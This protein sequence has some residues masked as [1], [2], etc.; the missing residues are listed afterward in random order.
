MHG[1]VRSRH[2]RTSTSNPIIW[3]A[4]VQLSVRVLEL[5]GFLATEDLAQIGSTMLQAG[6]IYSPSSICSRVQK[7]GE[8]NTQAELLGGQRINA[9]NQVHTPEC[10]KRAGENSAHECGACQAW[11]SGTARQR[12]KRRS[13]ASDNSISH[14]GCNT[15]QLRGTMYPETFATLHMS[16]GTGCSRRHGQCRLHVTP[17]TETGKFERAAAKQDSSGVRFDRARRAAVSRCWSLLR[18]LQCDEQV[19]I[20]TDFEQPHLQV[21]AVHR[22]MYPSPL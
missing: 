15:Q 4:N 19:S 2:E 16:V 7:R 18:S 22:L 8:N 20:P 17:H 10:R 21:R 6:T 13:Q 1:S 3:L 12:A 14:H 5:P 9:G 11:P